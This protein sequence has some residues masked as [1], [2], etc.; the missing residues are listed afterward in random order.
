VNAMN[1]LADSGFVMIPLLL[2]CVITWTIVFERIW[3]LLKFKSAYYHLDLKA[4]ELIAKNNELSELRE[5][6]SNIP[7]ILNAPYQVLLDSQEKNFP[8]LEERLERRLQEVHLDLKKY[9]WILAS[10]A[11]TAPFI[12]LFGTV[13]GIIH[14]FEDISKS[15]KGGFSVVAAGLSEALIATAA[16]II[17]A[18]IAVLF[19]NFFLNWVNSLS[20]DFKNRF[21]DFAAYFKK[22]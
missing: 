22:D 13:I 11:S 3:Y 12:G 14:C 9:L 18:V 21:I 17:I 2:F 8:D 4:Q 7:D 19:F 16:G 10:I 5:Y 15:G 1:L 20:S 6:C